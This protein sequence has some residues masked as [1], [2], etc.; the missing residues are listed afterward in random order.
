MGN[1]LMRWNYSNLSPQARV[2]SGEL[3]FADGGAFTR[4]K[5]VVGE[6]DGGRLTMHTRDAYDRG[7]NLAKER[8]RKAEQQGVEWSE[9]ER[10]DWVPL[11]ATHH[12][13]NPCTA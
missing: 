2:N 3:R 13:H 8:D 4:R 7:R 1:P 10:C 12:H 5:S 11:G 6:V 9:R